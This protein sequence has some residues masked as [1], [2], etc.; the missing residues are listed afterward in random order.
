MGLRL[1]ASVGDMSPLLAALSELAAFEALN[2]SRRVALAVSLAKL[3]GDDFRP[4]DTLAGSKGMVAVDHVP[5]GVSFVAIP[6]GSFEMGLRD[7][8]ADEADECLGSTAAVERTLMAVEAM[9][10]PV[11][12]VTVPPF[13]LAISHLS[14]AQVATMTASAIRVDALAPADAQRFGRHASGFRLPSEAELE[15]VGREGGDL[16]FL[17]DGG[18]VY[19]RTGR[20]PSP[21]ENGWGL[22]YLSTPTWTA[23]EWHDDYEGAPGTAAPWSGGGVPGAFR[24]GLVD[25][26]EQEEDLVL[27]LAAWR[28]RFV[29][30]DDDWFVGVRPAYAMPT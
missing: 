3:L 28:G 21:E 18:R 30:P 27:G 15:Y 24:G 1:R 8:D 10:T 11:H 5:T 16:R 6:G 29:L 25:P 7:D 9:C 19:A 14:S 22:S 4:R 20:W 2:Q 23:D 26:P 17:N 12:H 13:L